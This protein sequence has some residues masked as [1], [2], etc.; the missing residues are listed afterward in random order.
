[1]E[2]RILEVV[3]AERDQGL[4]IRRAEVE[5]RTSTC[6]LMLIHAEDRNDGPIETWFLHGYAELLLMGAGNG[7]VAGR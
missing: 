2:A 1:M 3:E 4:L 7:A 6:A 5:C